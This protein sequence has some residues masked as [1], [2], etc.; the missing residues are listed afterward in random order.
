MGRHSYG[1]PEVIAYDGENG[2]VI[3]G[4]FVSIAVDV[5]FFVGGG[6]PA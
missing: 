6:P 2:H 5:R 1:E 4:S 3:V